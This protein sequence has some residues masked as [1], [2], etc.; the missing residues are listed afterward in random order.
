MNIYWD[1]IPHVFKD[2]LIGPDQYD[3]SKIRQDMPYGV[4]VHNYGTFL[5][6]E[7]LTTEDELMVRLRFPVR[8]S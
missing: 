5:F 1:D 7:C 2:Y 8:T 4:K 6:I 3:L